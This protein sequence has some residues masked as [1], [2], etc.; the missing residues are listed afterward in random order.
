[1][2]VECRYVMFCEACGDDYSFHGWTRASLIA[3][4][5]NSGWRV[6]RGHECCPRCVAREAQKLFEATKMTR[7]QAASVAMR[8][9]TRMRQYL[10]RAALAKRKCS[11]S[12]GMPKGIHGSGCEMLTTGLHAPGDDE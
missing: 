2:S 3:D 4:A 8:R 10:D 9:P 6:V 12:P 11:C 7:A 1:M 5:S